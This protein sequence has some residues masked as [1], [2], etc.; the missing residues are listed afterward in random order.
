MSYL[1]DG[2]QSDGYSIKPG[3]RCRQKISRNVIALPN[4]RQCNSYLHKMGENSVRSE[5]MRE[6]RF[7]P[8]HPKHKHR[9]QLISYFVGNCNCLLLSSVC[10]TDPTM[11]REFPAFLQHRFQIVVFNIERVIASIDYKLPN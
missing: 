3:K 7:G 6:I 5:W 11:I 8:P 10:A 1:S 4:G 2:N 9:R